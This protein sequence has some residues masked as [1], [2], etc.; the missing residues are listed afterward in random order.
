M[1][2]SLMAQTPT[3]SFGEITLVTPATTPPTYNVNLVLST[4]GTS[5]TGQFAGLQFD[6]NY[7]PASLNVTIGL[8]AQT[9][10]LQVNTVCLTN[11]TGCTSYAQYNPSTTGTP[12]DTGGSPPGG[13]RA[14]IIGCCASGQTTPTANLIAQ[15]GVVATL[16]IQGTSSTIANPILTLKGSPYLAGTTSGIV[17]GQ[18]TGAQSIPM[19]IGA[20]SSDLNATGK[21]DFSKTY[22][23]GNV[24]PYT[25]DTVGSFGYTT[26]LSITF[27]DLIWS[28]FVITNAPTYS[29]PSA[30]SDRLDAMLQYP[31]DTPTIRGGYPRG[32]ATPQFN[33][34]IVELF[35]E[36]NAPGYTDRPVRPSL[37]GVCPAL[38]STLNASPARQVA[39]RHPAETEGTIVLGSS[40]GASAGQDRVPIYVRGGRD[41]AHLAVA[42]SLGDGQ[43]QLRF[44][45]APGVNPTIM[46]DAQPGFIAGAWV[47]GLDIRAGQQLLLG[48]VVGPAGSAPNLKVY[49]VS[50]SG[51]D[52]FREVGLD[53]SGAP[54]MRQ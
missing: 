2:A 28:L 23:V 53:V 33:D 5:Y 54:L 43:S 18:N 17:S 49:G 16:Q 22:L 14:I 20:G 46:Q 25:A 39:V 27:N 1:A 12:Q 4:A 41:L 13:Q 38:N 3:L 51:L 45:P 40:G 34:L 30:C 37:G 9:A 19:A 50:A 24:Y 48:Y 11:Y 15:D 35:R 6:L 26:P 44:E 42:F 31:L 29:A 21:L 7:D 10:N 32:A 52:D 8:G 36:T 47:T